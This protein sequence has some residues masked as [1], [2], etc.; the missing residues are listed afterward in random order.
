MTRRPGSLKL[1]EIFGIRVGVDA[2]WFVVL[3]LVIFALSAQFRDTLDSSDGVAYVTAVAS[4]LLFFASIIFH[5]LGHALA[6]R[7][8][9]I[10]T[11]SI[12]LWFFGGLARLSRDAR[13]PGE[14]FR[15]A[16]AGPL[17]TLAVII[18]CVGLGVALAGWD[19]YAKAAGLSGSGRVT[20]PLLLITW[21][22]TINVALLVFNLVPAYPLDGGRI[23]R[24]LVWR[25]TGDKGRGTRAAARLGQLFAY[26]LAGLGLFLIVQGTL[27][28]LYL[29]VLGFL[30]GSSS[31]GAILQSDFV[32]RIEGVRV[33]DIMDAE[34]VG[35]PSEL[36]LERARDEYFARFGDRWLPVV[37]PA[38]RVVGLLGEERARD[39]GVEPVASAMEAGEGRLIDEE[40]SLEDLVSSEPL[41][42]H[43]ALVAVDREGRLRGV[44]TLEQVRRALAGALAP[45]AV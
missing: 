43:G 44:V 1:V 13:T 31:R 24:A 17:A 38:G 18:V 27:A 11:S 25:L 34:P 32:E 14:E 39:G 8:E 19:T 2:S 3:F 40:R 10:E 45:P 5:E 36:P 37:D 16:A 9:G 28:G 42:R 21:L 29:L 12:H 22:A 23:A 33:A 41:R 30:F 4:A 26:L 35:L 15:M 7:R 6:A 20:A